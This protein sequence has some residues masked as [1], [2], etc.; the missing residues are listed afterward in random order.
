MHERAAS[1]YGT[2]GTLCG[3]SGIH[4]NSCLLGLHRPQMHELAKLSHISVR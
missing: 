4:I 3:I 2:T 1:L